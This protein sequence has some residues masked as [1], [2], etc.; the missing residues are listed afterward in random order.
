MHAAWRPTEYEPGLHGICCVD[1][2]DGQN[3]P[4]AHELQDAESPATGVK[5]PGSHATGGELLVA[6]AAP[7]GQAMQL[8]A[9]PRL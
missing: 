8:A 9:L 5:V 6:H 2:V 7:A 3:A 4:G 1:V